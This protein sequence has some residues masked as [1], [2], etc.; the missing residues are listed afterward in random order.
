MKAG[1]FAIF[2]GLPV[3][4]ESVNN[5]EALIRCCVEMIEGDDGFNDLLHGIQTTVSLKHL[6]LFTEESAQEL[7]ELY[8]D[9]VRRENTILK[10]IDDCL[11]DMHEY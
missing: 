4:I 1:D 6:T 11:K 9:R 3:A 8:M 7:R 2:R 5:G 10:S